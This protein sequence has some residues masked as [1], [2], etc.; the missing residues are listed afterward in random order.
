MIENEIIGLVGSVGF[1]IAITLYLLLERSKIT[2]EL[3]TAVNNL[4]LI[5]KTKLK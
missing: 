3:T 1:P 5:I 4:T 2:K